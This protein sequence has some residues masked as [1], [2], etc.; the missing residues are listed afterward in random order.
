VR[1]VTIAGVVLA[2]LIA[3]GQ[4]SAAN[5]QVFLGEQV[6]CGFIKCKGVSGVP[7][8]TT[9]DQ[10][11]PGTVTINAGDTVT[12]SSAS[13]HT[14]SYSKQPAA[15]LL[16]DPAKG[17]YGPLDDAAGSPFYFVG[18]GKF[19]YNGLAF[20]PYGPKTVSGNTPTS[21]GALSPAGPKAKPATFTYTFP[22]AGTYT[23]WCNVHPGMKGKV[24]VEPAGSPV[25]KTPPQVQAQAL[26]ETNAA[27]AQAKALA[28]AAKPPANTVYVGIGGGTTVLGY[29]PQTLTVK[30]GTTVTYTNKSSTEVHNLVFGPKKY[31]LGMEKKTDLLPTGPKAPNQVSPF[32]IYGSEPKGQYSYDGTNHG[33]GYFV[34]PLTI[35]NKA[36]PLPQTWKV[37]Y[38]K[39]GTY[40]FFCWIH[41][42]DMGGTTVVTK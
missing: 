16:P 17:K 27:W 37:T 25:P 28:D 12:F 30:A 35:G 4:A 42:P 38:T 32:L 39:P 36:V 2:V 24:V 19:I 40:K 8:G 10:F 15:L 3:A 13:F 5:Y 18:L 41:G 21:S 29:F 14:V 31:I 9:L 11:L 26:A 23:L 34:T 20:A 1:R 22:K 7:K 33:N 6:P